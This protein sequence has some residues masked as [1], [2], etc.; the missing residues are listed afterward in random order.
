MG[1]ANAVPVSVV[2]YLSHVPESGGLDTIMCKMAPVVLACAVV[3]S[4][5]VQSLP[6]PSLQLELEH[7]LNTYSA[8]TGQAYGFAAGYVGDDGE[9]FG[10]GAGEKTT[11]ASNLP[12][13]NGTWGSTK[14]AKATSP[15]SYP[16]GGMTEN[17]T[18]ILGSGSKPYTVSNRSHNLTTLAVLWLSPFAVHK[19]QRSRASAVCGCLHLPCTSAHVP[20]E[21]CK[22]SPQVQPCPAAS[23]GLLASGGSGG[24][25]AGGGA[26]AGGP[27]TTHTPCLRCYCC[28]WQAAGIMRLVEQG[29]LALEDKVTD[30]TDGMF[31]AVWNTTLDELFGGPMRTVT[32]ANLVMMQSGLADIE[33]VPGWER[34]ALFNHSEHDPI[35]DLRA[36]G[37]LAH[38]GQG[39][40]R[41]SQGD[42]CTWHFTPGSETEYCSTNF[43][44]AGLVLMAHQPQSTWTTAYWK[45]FDQ[46]TTLG[47]GFAARYPHTFFPTCGPLH[48]VG[49]SDVGNCYLFGRAAIWQQDAGI[50]GLGWGGA[51]VSALDVA[52][53]YHDL[54]GPRGTVVEVTTVAKMEQW[55][56]LTYGW[57]KGTKRYGIG[58]ETNNPSP[59]VAHTRAGGRVGMIATLAHPFIEARYVTMSPDYAERATLT[60]TLAPT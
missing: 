5:Q 23:R 41:G 30:V 7:I 39:C 34:D 55:R 53:F 51:T 45:T 12:A 6:K 57:S 21:P 4:A 56:L 44:L 29:H 8:A 52:R 59:Q 35:W 46:R 24:S 2:E 27:A 11:T 19:C 43:L 38:T 1:V 32:V 26:G 13:P 47:E 40:T 3:A 50:M 18:F 37:S 58:L 33:A 49:L 25:G 17:D 54:L 16:K 31:R 42:A 60:L 48:S 28:A 14:I 36:V 20:T 22:C 9:R 15:A 10:A